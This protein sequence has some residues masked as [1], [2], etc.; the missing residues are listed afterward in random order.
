MP[1]SLVYIAIYWCLGRLYCNS[2][3]SLHCSYIP[4]LALIFCQLA[5]LNT[6]DALRKTGSQD[7][8]YSLEDRGSRSGGN[9]QSLHRSVNALSPVSRPF[10]LVAS[11]VAEI[12]ETPFQRWPGPQVAVQIETTHDGGPTEVSTRALA[13]R[14]SRTDVLSQSKDS[15]VSPLTPGIY[16]RKD[17]V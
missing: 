10:I 16:S 8:N 13:G 4:V 7:V 5:A 17:M 11:M 2:F 9:G 12:A 3:V 14:L 6:R 15:F 1:N